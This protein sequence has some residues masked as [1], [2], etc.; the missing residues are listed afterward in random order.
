MISFISSLD[1]SI[2]QELYAAQTPFGVRA[3]S[4]ITELGSVALAIAALVIACLLLWKKGRIE[5]AIGFAVS[6][7]GAMAASEI[8]KRLVERARPPEEW[9]AVVETGFSFPSNHAAIAA[10][11]YGFLAYLA[12]KLAPEK[13]RGALV[14]LSMLLILLIGFSRLYLGVHYASDILGGL[15]LGALFVALGI[16]AV[17]RIRAIRSL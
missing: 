10:A 11:L 9:R 7:L 13:L 1:A 12:W 17:R 5:Y 3:F 16:E 14:A 15:I 2:G 4:L 8:L 6:V